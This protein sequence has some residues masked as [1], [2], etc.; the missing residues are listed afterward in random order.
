MEGEIHKIL[1]VELHYRELTEEDEG[2]NVA[3]KN[4]WGAKATWKVFFLHMCCKGAI[5]TM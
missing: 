3:W 1:L 4:V 5:L 2:K